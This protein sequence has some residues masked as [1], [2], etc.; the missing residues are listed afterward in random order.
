MNPHRNGAKRGEGTVHEHPASRHVTTAAKF[1]RIKRRHVY[2]LN[3]VVADLGI[4]M[5][6]WAD[7]CIQTECDYISR[8]QNLRSA[9]ALRLIRERG[10]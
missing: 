3:V 8:I 1:M 10:P 7:F 2:D 4:N 5:T 9:K 6:K